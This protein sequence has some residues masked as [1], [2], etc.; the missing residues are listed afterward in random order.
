MK[1]TGKRLLSIK[2]KIDPNRL[3]PVSEALRFL[4]AHSRVKFQESV[5]LSVRLGINPKKSDQSVRGASVLPHGHGR[6]IRV[7][8][9]TTADKAQ[10]AKD[11]GADAVGLEDLAEQFKSG[12]FHYDRVIA[13][14]DAMAVVAPLG[15]LLGPR[16][17][18]PNPKTGTVSDE[19]AAAVRHAKAGQ[20]PFKNDK[21]GIV[22]ASIGRIDF[23]E[24]QLE[25][26]LRALMADLL[27]AKPPSAKGVY[28]RKVSLSS[29]MGPSFN[30]TQSAAA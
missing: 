14:P 24:S 27:K 13:S 21:A 11:A 9:F 29:T 4:K 5:D 19:L 22:H 8:V 15:Q 12:R 20:V 30:V 1:K 7:A 23:S 17:L 18:M 2:E 10:A 25:E 3:Y 26:N 16:G 28:I 6:K